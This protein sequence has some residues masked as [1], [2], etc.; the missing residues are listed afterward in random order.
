MHT[1]ASGVTHCDKQSERLP[2]HHG[3]MAMECTE[4]AG[5]TQES[6][7]GMRTRIMM[8]CAAPVQLCT[9]NAELKFDVNQV[10]RIVGEEI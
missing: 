1:A 7:R 3:G 5:A 9:A 10:V 4:L 6:G 2:R 8:V